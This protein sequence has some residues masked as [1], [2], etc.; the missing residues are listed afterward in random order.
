MEELFK[1]LD[2]MNDPEKWAYLVER[3]PDGVTVMLDNDSTLISEDD[4][5]LYVKFD[6]H[7][8]RSRGTRVLLEVIGIANDIY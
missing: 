8:G 5:D 6:T 3:K 7:I 4:G 1:K 2:K